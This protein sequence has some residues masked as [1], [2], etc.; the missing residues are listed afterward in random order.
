M[1]T[2]FLNIV[3]ILWMLVLTACGGSGGGSATNDGGLPAPT[4][5]PIDGGASNGLSQ[6]YFFTKADPRSISTTNSIPTTSVGVANQFFIHITQAQNAEMSLGIFAPKC[7]VGA[8]TNSYAMVLLSGDGPS[9]V[10]LRTSSGKIEIEEVSYDNNLTQKKGE[11]VQALAGDCNEG[12]FLSDDTTTVAI[13]NDNV[14]VVTDSS[15]NIYIGLSKNISLNSLQNTGLQVSAQTTS[16]SEASINSYHFW[17][18]NIPLLGVTN[19]SS[20]G[21][22]F[23]N[24]QFFGIY[25]GAIETAFGNGQASLILNSS[26]NIESHHTVVKGQGAYFARELRGTSGVIN[27]KTVF[28]G[29]MSSTCI[30]TQGSYTECFGVDALII[31]SEQE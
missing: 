23:D 20:S 31:A 13:A 2:K 10:S 17:Q 9:L 6:Y 18:S 27:G 11:E 22:Y 3:I 29:S 14:A 12:I 4:P 24:G 5:I 25:N 30:N 21:G 7:L 15:G 16:L 28:F 1:N 19:Q 26:I 8:T